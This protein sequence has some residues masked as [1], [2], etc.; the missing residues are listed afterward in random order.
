MTMYSFEALPNLVQH[1]AIL[2]IVIIVKLIIAK[3]SGNLS[4]THGMQYF[5]FYCQRLSDKV[6]KSTNSDHQQKIAGLI[7][8]LITLAPLIV[9][10]WL[11]EE[12]VAIEQLWQVL[13]LYMALGHFNLSSLSNK[14]SRALTNNDKQTA[15]SLLQE[16]CLRD[17]RQLSAMGLSKATIE[18]QLIKHI[19]LHIVV[20]F[21]YLLIGPIAALAYRL[22]LEMHYSWNT[23][24]AKFFY[25]GQA[26][27][28][29]MQLITWLPTRVYYTTYLLTTIGHNFFHFWRVTRQSFFQ[30]T[31]NLLVELHALNLNIQLGGVAMYNQQKLRRL[32]FNTSGNQPLVTDINNSSKQLLIVDIALVILLI[33]FTYI[34]V[35][36]TR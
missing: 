1:T 25:F 10:L 22:V 11:F 6:N 34:S 31:P 18:M 5:Q 20:S 27:N 8:L 21:C 13:L 32:G 23:K 17:T 14:I 36:F 29:L 33:M 26:S 19:Q 7:A 28:F 24:V 12:F 35:L 4:A 15:K 16:N 9:I 3:F 30:L 2:A